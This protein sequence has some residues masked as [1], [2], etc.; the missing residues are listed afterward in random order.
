MS[1]TDNGAKLMHEAAYKG[2]ADMA[3]QLIAGRMDVNTA[4]KDD[5]DTP[6]CMAA[7]QGHVD[8][9]ELLIDVRADFN[10]AS[11]NYGLTPLHKAILGDMCLWWSG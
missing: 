10:K 11:T 9:V 5:G 3:E 4:R 6:L 8:V 1:L 2:H 7:L